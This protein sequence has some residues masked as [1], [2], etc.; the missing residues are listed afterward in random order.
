MVEMRKFIHDGLIFT[1]KDVDGYINQNTGTE[2]LSIGEIK[3]FLSDIALFKYDEELLRRDISRF[4]AER[5]LDVF[6]T[7]IGIFKK[8]PFVE[9]VPSIILI[10]LIGFIGGT[11]W[12]S[13]FWWGLGYILIISCI[14]L[15]LVFVINDNI[16]SIL[17]IYIP[18]S[19]LD[20][21]FVATNTIIN[22]KINLVINNLTRNYFQEIVRYLQN[23]VIGISSILF[24][25][26][27]LW[28]S[29][30]IKNRRTRVDL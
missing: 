11:N 1:E 17:S 29:S 25:I 16:S 15:G 20:D 8:L 30:Y 18:K 7:T 5:Y 2:D 6:R 28:I 13:R 26:S 24:V 27:V 12:I 19:L 9:Y 14:L 22:T 23:S 10:I 3:R 21:S 4:T